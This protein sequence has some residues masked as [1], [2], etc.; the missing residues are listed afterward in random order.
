[1]ININDYIFKKEVDTENHIIATYSVESGDQ[2]AAAK[3]I[4]I[5]QSIGNPDVRTQ[6]DSPE[7]LNNNLAKIIGKPE[8]FEGKTKGTIQIAYP[9]A[10]FGKG[11]GVTQL[12]CELMG[13]QMDIDNITACRLEDVDLPA[14]YL[15][16]YQG[17]K[18]GMAEI[19]RRTGAVGR[20]LLGGIVKPK[21]GIDIPQL[22]EL[23]DELLAGGV[24]FI[25]E[26]EILG[27]PANCDF[28]ERVP[29]FVE[30]V[31]KHEKEQGREIFYT[32]CINSDFPESLKRAE[33]AS[34]V[35]A[36]GVHI[37]FHAGL[38]VYKTLRDA[39]LESAIFFQKSGDKVLTGENNKYSI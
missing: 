14:E 35:G 24:D 17:P 3:Q 5:G 12:L 38:G 22:L 6:R 31:K 11:D 28:Y 32:P 13:G 9:L 27:N 39:D 15:S 34:E 16:Q 29:K 30:L 26:D 36:K 20:P 1:M 21:I 8:D 33:W 18:I 19:K 25:K 23:G 7:I 4:A 2:L 37:N 10:N